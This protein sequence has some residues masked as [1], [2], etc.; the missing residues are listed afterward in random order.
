MKYDLYFHNDF[1]GRA[2]AA[3]MLA[4]LRSRGDDIAR[5]F[6]MTYGY[7]STWLTKDFSREKNPAIVV[8]FLYHPKAAWWFDH[9]ATAFKKA[10]WKKAFK[11][12]NHHRYDPSCRSACRFVCASLKKDF[13]WKPPRHLRVLAKWLDIFDSGGYRSAKE[14]IQMKPPAYQ[15]NAFIEA[16]DHT[17]KED[18]L[19]I[20]LLATQPLERIVK[21]PHIARAIR[22]MQKKVS[23]SVEFYRKHLQVFENNTFID[24][25]EDPLGGFLRFT[26]YYLYPKQ[27]FHVRLRKKGAG[28]WYLGVGANPWHRSKNRLPL[29]VM[30]RRKYGGGGHH[31]AGAAEFRTRAEA[32]RAFEKINALL[33]R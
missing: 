8:D 1:D 7:E 27:M 19:L 17:A 31:N 4:F 25:T 21:V 18:R 32:M 9:H 16:R 22:A 12:D 23:A 14:T 11:S 6:P 5:Y 29:G 20:E 33:N 13:G 10:Q 2:A 15:M 26:P 24:L 3:V 28:V 30:M